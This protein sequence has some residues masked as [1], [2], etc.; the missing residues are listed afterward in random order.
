MMM[1]TVVQV[2]EHGYSTGNEVN[3]WIQARE[4]EG[5]QF[6]EQ[7]TVIGG[8]E[9]RTKTIITVVMEKERGVNRT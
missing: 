9:H 5:F 6:K 4:Q 7:T 2:F 3:N 8:T 1:Q